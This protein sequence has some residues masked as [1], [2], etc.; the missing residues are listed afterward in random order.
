MK[1]IMN[2]VHYYFSSVIYLRSQKVNY[3]TKIFEIRLLQNNRE[4]YNQIIKAKTI[5]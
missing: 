1:Q 3:L 4:K 5:I 2:Q